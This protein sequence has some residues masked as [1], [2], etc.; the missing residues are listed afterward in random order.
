MTPN[1]GLAFS[2]FLRQN[3]AVVETLGY[4]SGTHDESGKALSP[5]LV[6]MP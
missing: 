3:T 1:E 4:R 2:E 5:A 6:E